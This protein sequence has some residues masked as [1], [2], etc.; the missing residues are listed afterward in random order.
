MGLEGFEGFSWFRYFCSFF[1]IEGFQVGHG[2]RM[3]FGK[4]SKR[5]RRHGAIFSG[6][7]P[8]KWV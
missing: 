4:D 3:G 7:G 5:C 6:K 2:Q 1:C 8:W